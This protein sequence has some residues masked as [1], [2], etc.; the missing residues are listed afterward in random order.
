MRVAL[1][2]W[3]T[4]GDIR[5]FFSLARALK[6]RGHDVN[7]DYVSVEGRTFEALARTC[8]VDAKPLAGEYFRENRELIRKLAAESLEYASPPRQFELILRDLMDP[9]AEALL[10]RSLELAEWSDVV[11]AHTLAHPAAT[12]AEKVGRPLALIALQPVFRSRRY[13]PAGASD[14]GRF[15]NPL[16]WKIADWVM[17]S[18]LDP[19]IAKQRAALGMAPERFD[20]SRVG[21]SRKALLAV[22]PTLFARPDDWDDGIVSTGFLSVPETGDSW[23]PSPELAAFLDAGSAPVF[24]SFGSM[25]SLNEDLAHGAVRIF[26]D[27]ARMAKQ[28][29]LIQCP[30]AAR[31][32]VEARDD[33]RF[34]D[35][36]PHAKVFPRCSMVVHHGGAG[37][38]QSVLLAGRPSVVVPHAADQFYWGDVLHGRA[39]AAKPIIRKRL[40]ARALAERIRYV[41][42]RPA[43][44]E[45][46]VALSSVLAGEDG[47]TATA[48]EV[49]RM[50]TKAPPAGA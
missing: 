37:T 7:L 1:I 15:L 11:V 30:Q 28:R 24:A 27:A 4:E 29:V 18:T 19:R 47:P 20:A 2:S 31:E 45:R 41:L 25:F 40:T 5:P 38:T 9:I 35:H 14:G 42:D 17:R 43:L 48:I 10:S 12:A 8:G 22:S 34:I 6:Q 49:E 36:A 21:P 50:L 26:V 39:V 46:A 44:T 16:L 32:G 33:V 23:A 13:P 3:G